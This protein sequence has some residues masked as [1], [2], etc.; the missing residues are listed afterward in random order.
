MALVGGLVAKCNRKT[1]LNLN[2]QACRGIW[3][4]WRR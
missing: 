4:G 3:C 2:G 1:N